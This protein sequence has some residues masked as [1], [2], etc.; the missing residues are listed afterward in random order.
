[1]LRGNVIHTDSKSYGILTF[2]L[3]LKTRLFLLPPHH[4][5]FEGLLSL[6]KMINR[7]GHMMGIMRLLCEKLKPY[8]SPPGHNRTSCTASSQPCLNSLHS[9][10][11]YY[12][13]FKILL[14]LNF[15][16]PC[17][18]SDCG[19]WAQCFNVKWMPESRRWTFCSCLL[20]S[21]FCL[22]TPETNCSQRA[23]KTILLNVLSCKW[24]KLKSA[25][26]CTFSVVACTLWIQYL[27][28]LARWPIWS[29]PAVDSGCC[30][31]PVQMG[32]AGFEGG[33]D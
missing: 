6:S 16:C 2:F 5:C 1:M 23:E 17:L 12:I 22:L 8:L 15:S 27:V 7:M 4:V 24:M 20:F 14:N 29:S 9:I 3:P 11:I 30:C 28:S 10:T 21:W 33:K 26:L 31:E 13:I 19:R 32:T 25:H 18:D